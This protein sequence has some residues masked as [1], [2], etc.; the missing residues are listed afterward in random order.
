MKILTW[1]TDE[2]TVTTANGVAHYDIGMYAKSER[3]RYFS[4][5]C[6]SRIIL[7]STGS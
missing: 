3:S 5:L 2:L 7:P 1:D 6:R 4:F